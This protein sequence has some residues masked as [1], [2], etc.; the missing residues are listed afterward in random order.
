MVVPREVRGHKSLYSLL[1]HL[2]V[3]GSL[4]YDILMIEALPPVLLT[5]WQVCSHFD[6]H[7]ALVEAVIVYDKVQLHAVGRQG[8]ASSLFEEAIYHDS[9]NLLQQEVRESL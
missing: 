1:V 4:R 3:D 5:R 2:E 7:L 6:N 8:L 9:L